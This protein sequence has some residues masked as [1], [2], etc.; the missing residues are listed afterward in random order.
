MILR[1]AFVLL[2]VAL[3]I[4][5][6]SGYKDWDSREACRAELHSYGYVPEEAV[7]AQSTLERCDNLTIGQFESAVTLINWGYY[8]YET[9]P[10]WMK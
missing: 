10:V 7:P 4:S 2:V 1:S 3:G 8:S 9:P 5:H 6:L